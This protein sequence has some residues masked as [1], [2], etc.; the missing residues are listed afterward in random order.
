[1]ESRLLPNNYLKTD[2]NKTFIISLVPVA[3]GVIM[4]FGAPIPKW[5]IEPD[6]SNYG[7]KWK[8]GQNRWFKSEP[9]RW[10]LNLTYDQ[11]Q[12]VKETD[13]KKSI[14]PQNFG[15]NSAPVFDENPRFTQVGE[16]WYNR[17]YKEAYI[18]C[19]EGTQVLSSNN[20][21]SF[22]SQLE[23]STTPEQKRLYLTYYQFFPPNVPTSDS[24]AKGNIIWFDN[25]F[26]VNPTIQ[27][28]TWPEITPEPNKIATTEPWI[29]MVDAETKESYSGSDLYPLVKESGITIK[30][31]I[32][33]PPIDMLRPNM[34]WYNKAENRVKQYID[35]EIKDFIYK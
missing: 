14:N 5:A 11:A 6:T 34:V 9:E 20:P 28:K 22:W 1:M 16:H 8:V 3:V 15:T 4:G 23:I 12:F 18:V 24:Y 13:G 7:N 35:C 25:I 32:K 33:D 17:K 21:A 29:K 27:E 19:E 31:L 26:W 2:M 30:S 10:H